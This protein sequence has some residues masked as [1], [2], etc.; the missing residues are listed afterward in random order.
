MYTY[1]SKN[2]D[3]FVCCSTKTSLPLNEIASATKYFPNESINMRHTNKIIISCKAGIT[4][5]I[6][7]SH[8]YY[9]YDTSTFHGMS[10][11]FIA[12]II[13]IYIPFYYT[14]LYI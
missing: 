11:Y 6:E 5:S 14:Y 9:K 8:A 3:I 12:H 1:I 10:Y 2:Q 4:K 13:Y 7:K